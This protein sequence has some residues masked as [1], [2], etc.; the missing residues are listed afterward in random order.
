[1]RAFIACILLF[2]YALTSTGATVYMHQCHGTQVF[3]LQEGIENH[4][5]SC[6]ICL[7]HHHDGSEEH[8]H[9]HDEKCDHTSKDCC[10]DIVLDLKKGQEKVESASTGFSFPTLTPTTLTLFWIVVF[11]DDIEITESATISDRLANITPT[12]PPYLVHCNFRI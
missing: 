10:N 5:A 12:Q 9:T 6:S 2:F 4:H 11:H 3:L 1:M 8:Q 7:D